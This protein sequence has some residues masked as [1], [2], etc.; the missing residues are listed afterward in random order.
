[1]AFELVCYLNFGYPTIEDGVRDAELYIESG[2]TAL[3]LDI[4]SRDPYLEHDFV[5]ERMKKCLEVEPDYEKYFDGIRQIHAA[6]PE[7][8]L[9]FMLYENTIVELGVQ[10]I[11]DFCREV[12]IRYTSYVGGSGE[13]RNALAQAGLGICCYVQ[14]HLPDE[15]VDFARQSTGP[16]LY[17]A[18]SVGRTGHGCLSFDDGVHYLRQSGLSMPIYASVGIK[19]PDDIRAAKAARADGAFIGSVLMAQLNNK[20]KLRA[21]IEE[22]TAAAK[23]DQT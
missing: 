10:R 2:C 15:E 23:E 18:R 9:Y 14:Y 20:E 22:F 4:P 5:K 11:V 19:T 3:Q 16:V 1:M 7:V 17:Q 21:L 6:H 12:G 13:V 8:K